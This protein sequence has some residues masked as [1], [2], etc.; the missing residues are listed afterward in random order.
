MA[1]A[2][3]DLGQSAVL[4]LGSLSCLHINVVQNLIDASIVSRKSPLQVSRFS[5]TTG[6]AVASIG[7][8]QILSAKIRLKLLQKHQDQR[9]FVFFWELFEGR[10]LYLFQVQVQVTLRADDCGLAVEHIF[11]KVSQ[12]QGRAFVLLSRA[13]ELLLQLVVLILERFVVI[14]AQGKVLLMC[15]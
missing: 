5:N 14:L 4:V 12:D 3:V 8:W 13:V 10:L 2:Y 15:L 1:A 6:R 9:H 7:Y 11:Q